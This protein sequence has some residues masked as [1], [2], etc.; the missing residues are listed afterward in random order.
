MWGM[1]GLLEFEP[2]FDCLA[3]GLRGLVEA[4]ELFEPAG[5]VHLLGGGEEG[6]VAGGYDNFDEVAGFETTENLGD[7]PTAEA[8]ALVVG[9][10]A[11]MPNYRQFGACSGVVGGHAY[12]LAV[13]GSDEGASSDSIGILKDFAIKPAHRVFELVIPD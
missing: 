2:V 3:L 11:V 4:A 7:L 6:M 10:D 1:A 13:Q 12:G 8:L 9:Q 5:L